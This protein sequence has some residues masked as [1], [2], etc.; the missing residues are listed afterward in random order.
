[1]HEK[2]EILEIFLQLV[3]FKDILS[4]QKMEQER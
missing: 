3:F 1:M 4:F 2:N